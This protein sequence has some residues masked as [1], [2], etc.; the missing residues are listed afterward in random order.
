M[1]DSHRGSEPTEL[2]HPQPA[3]SADA[4][5]RGTTN[6]LL[7]G[8]SNEEWQVLTPDLRRVQL[9][10]RQ[11]L[12]YAK[13]P[14]GLVHFVESGLVSVSA[15]LA[16]SKWV[17]VWLIGS[18]GMTG[19]P[20]VLDDSEGPPLQRTV[21]V[22]GSALCIPTAAF[23]AA[24]ESSPSLTRKMRRYVQVVL[25]QTAQSGA[26]NSHHALKQRLA[27]W[28]LL[29]RD[30][31]GQDEIPLSHA[32][33]GRLLGVRRPSITECLSVLNGDGA[34]QSGR[35]LIRIIDAEALEAIS[36]DCHRLI[37]REYARLLGSRL[38]STD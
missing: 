30:A 3:R 11:T 27:R 22:G 25:S 12:H 4:G 20:V 33:L 8:L 7:A 14:M 9:R 2:L 21:Q 10:P 37:R 24:M 16:P 36:C 34:V 13:M 5:P 28:L 35:R 38:R 31:L 23:R 26:C 18:E 17:E 15:R 1:D 29:A 6:R 32:V 19:I